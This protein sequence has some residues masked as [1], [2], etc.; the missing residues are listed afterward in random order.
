M[1]TPILLITFNRPDETKQVLNVILGQNPEEIYVFQ[2]GPRKD[3]K[4][5]AEA[6]AAVRDIIEK[7]FDNVGDGIK[8]HFL[9]SERNYGCGMGPVT[10]IS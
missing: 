1:K 9:F 3:N 6:C 5:D 10:A 7:A 4:N 2:D 8:K